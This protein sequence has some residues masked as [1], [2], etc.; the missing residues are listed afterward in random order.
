MS[1]PERVT[2]LVHHQLERRLSREHHLVAPGRAVEAAVAVRDGVDDVVIAVGVVP[3]MVG[4]NPGGLHDS[5]ETPVGSAAAAWIAA[6]GGEPGRHVDI[7]SHLPERRP[8]VEGVRFV[9]GALD[10]GDGIRLRA[11]GGEHD[12]HALLALRGGA[13]HLRDGD[14]EESHRHAERR[15]GHAVSMRLPESGS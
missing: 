6:E 3:R 7:E 11:R 12:Q 10:V 9:N 15:T 8:P 5:L 1:E 2:E 14:R 4:R 13:G